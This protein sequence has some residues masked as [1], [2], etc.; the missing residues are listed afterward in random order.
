MITPICLKTSSPVDMVAAISQYI[1]QNYS[2]DVA[3][4]HRSA[5]DQVNQER[6]KAIA[7][8]N[9]PTLSLEVYIQIFM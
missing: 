9:N 8:S 1:A 4:K 3:E 2:K 5:C 7:I 6:S